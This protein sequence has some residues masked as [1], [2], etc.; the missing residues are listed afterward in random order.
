MTDESVRVDKWL[1]AARFF[2]SRTLAAEACEGGKVDLN[3]HTAKPAKPVRPGDLLRVTLPGGKKLVKVLA[4]AHRRGPAAG[5]L[6]L[7]EDLTPPPA[8]EPTPAPPPVFRP[9]GLGRPTKRERRLLGRLG[10][11]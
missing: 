11:W 8:P 10:R 4:L 9:R 7:Y 1:W 5:A 2:K 3:D 6:L